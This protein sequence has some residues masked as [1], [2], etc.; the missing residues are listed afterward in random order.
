ML[1]GSNSTGLSSRR[2]VFASPMNVEPNHDVFIKP[3]HMHLLHNEI[4]VNVWCF[5]IEFS[6]GRKDYNLN[7]A[8]PFELKPEPGPSKIII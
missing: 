5:T 3:N 1:D 4:N 7:L 8:D 6:M 2:P